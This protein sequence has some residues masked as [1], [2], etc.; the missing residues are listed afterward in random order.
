MA[1]PTAGALAGIGTGTIVVRGGTVVDRLGRRRADVV[2]SEGMITF[3][4]EP[5]NA[6]HPRRAE[7]LDA[8]GCLVLPGLVDLHTHAREPGMEQAE[9]LESA[10][11]AASLGGYT[12][13]VVM[14]NTEPC[15]DS[16]P[17][18]RDV[19]EMAGKLP[20]EVAVA[21]AITV[22][23][24]GEVMAPIAEMAEAGVRLFT[25]DGRGVQDA[26]LMRRALEY[27]AAL[28]VVLAE[29]CEDE[30]LASGGHMHEGEASSFLGVPG[31]PREA[32]ESMVARDIMLSR[33][34]GARL[35]LLH[36]SSAGSAGMVAAAKAGGVRVSAEVT[37]HHLLLTEWD[38]S[39]YDTS[40]KMNPP[41]R[42]S[43]DAIAL[44][45]ALM[46]GAIDVVATDHAPHAPE[47]KEE[48]F[49]MAPFGTIGLG[50]AMA[51]CLTALGTSAGVV[52]RLAVA[53]SEAPASIAGLEGTQGG[54]LAAGRPG[55]LCVVCPDEEW[56]V[57]AGGM[58]SK[59]RNSAFAGR[60]LSGRVRHT[61]SQ[62][63]PLVVDGDLR[64]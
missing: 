46:S 9:D 47:A 31:I 19:A 20:V 18:V 44:R 52:E 26:R 60:R 17:A 28:P 33:M 50:T 42:A 24:R 15:A 5:G 21:G 16:A 12:A 32:E 29:H 55:N 54:P 6:D 25:D 10:C 1:D 27:A 53:M 61:V 8:S 48:A 36:L 7:V 64:W 34:T 39:S 57:P 43:S 58:G 35:H 59:S 38:V 41:L 14:P 37:P 49:E 30:R 3:V 11:R 51:A 22:G 4:G 45:E 40:T 63:V 23:R 13:I 56:A 62:G 2:V